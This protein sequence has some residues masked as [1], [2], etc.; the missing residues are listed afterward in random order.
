MI[1]NELRMLMFMLGFDETIDPLAMINMK[2][3]RPK[4]TW[5]KWVRKNV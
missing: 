1:K 5:K 2:N 4:E 3:G